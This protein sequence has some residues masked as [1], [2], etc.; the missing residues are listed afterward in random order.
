LIEQE[1]CQTPVSFLYQP[2]FGK[3]GRGGIFK[4]FLRVKEF[5]GALAFDNPGKEMSGQRDLIRNLNRKGLSIILAM[6]E[7]P[8]D[9]QR[10]SLRQ[11]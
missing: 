2:P 8:F 4:R 5:C 3:G 1:L 7:I 6:V 10:L 9:F 11:S